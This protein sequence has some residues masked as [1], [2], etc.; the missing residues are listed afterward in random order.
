M[1]PASSPPIAAATV[2]DLKGRVEATLPPEM[3]D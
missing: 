1:W 3:A 2:F